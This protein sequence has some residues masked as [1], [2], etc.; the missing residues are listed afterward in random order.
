V[1]ARWPSGWHVNRAAGTQARRGIAARR[2]PV[3][4]MQSFAT[5]VQGVPLTNG[6]A[7]GV[8]GSATIELS[9]SPQGLGTTWYPVM[10]VVSSS[11][12]AADTS[13]AACYLGAQVQQTLQGG[14]SY[15]GG[16]SV[17]ALSVASMTPGDLLIVVWTGATPGA[18]Y[19][20]N[21]IG[22]QDVLAWQQ[23]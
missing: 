17:I 20:F 15:A 14:Q 1:T 18:T 5:P 11:I 19:A 8:A 4:A 22:T 6:Q 21:T 12:G 9:V 10:V 2:I 7:Q 3:V 16:G 23:T 13:T